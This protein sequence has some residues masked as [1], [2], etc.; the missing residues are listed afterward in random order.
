[1]SGAA[2]FHLNSQAEAAT[3]TL[4]PLLVEAERVAATV[5]LGVHGRKR[6]GPGE[7]FW[8][9]RPYSFGDSTQ[10]IDWHKSA[11]SDRVYIREN[12]WEAANTLWLWSSPAPTMDFRSHLSNTSK[13]DR[14]DLIA[15]AMGS[16]AVR[17]HER[18]G[19]IGA[20]MQPGHSRGTLLRIAEWLLLHEGPPLPVM[21]PVQRFSSIVAL[22]DFLQPV[23]EIATAVTRMAAT[24]ASGHI[25]QVTD[26][27]E[28]TLPYNGRVEFRAIEGTQRYLAD[29]TESLR[30]AYIRRFNQH[31]DALREL[32]RRVGWTFTV[33]R[34]DESA[35]KILMTLHALVGG[36]KSRAFGMIVS[37]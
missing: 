20:P 9:Y 25:I 37:A 15:L 24:G 11:R 33:H 4:P 30:E 6:A 36:S 3:H 29:K 14:A 34:T 16:L 28:E 22:G 27:A 23:A 2:A 8:Q 35:L 13:R 31:R 7:S 10:R 21:G 32:A 26:P 12:E 17:A 5:I 19:A 18:V 1:M